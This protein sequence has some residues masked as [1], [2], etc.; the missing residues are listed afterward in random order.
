MTVSAATMGRCGPRAW[1][2]LLICLALAMPGTGQAAPIVFQSTDTPPFWSPSLPDNGVGGAMLRLLSAN[3]GVEYAIEYLPVKRFRNSQA[4]YIVGDPDILLSGGQRAILPIGIFRSAFFYYKPR[5]DVIQF[6]SLNDLQ[7]HTLGVL[8]GTLED[9]AYFERNGIRV[10]ESD[11]AESL[12]RK[13]KRG[14][15]DFCILVRAA[16]T[17][18]IRQMYPE[19]EARFASVDIP[20]TVR[21]IAL[22]I[23]TGSPE[24][25]QVAQRYREV[26]DRTLASAAYHQILED[27]YGKGQVPADRIEYLKKFR[28]IYA[29]DEDK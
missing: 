14:R 13:L 1:A 4:P 23:D 8:R 11:S 12:L 10:E 27:F 2:C 9:R 19:E 6:R 5:H 3:A 28:Q 18:L 26:L 21:P 16:G 24:G 22:M 7:G 25:R 29:S 20:G 17:Y 15:I